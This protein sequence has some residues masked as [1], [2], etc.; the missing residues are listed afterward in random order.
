MC[1]LVTRQAVDVALEKQ[2]SF[3]TS[4]VV[5]VVDEEVFFVGSEEEEE[6]EEEVWLDDEVEV[7][8]LESSPPVSGVGA[9]GSVI[10]QKPLPALYP[11][12]PLIPCEVSIP[13]T[14]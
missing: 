13:V 5:V 12:P 11:T 2:P 6:E 10:Q 8:V 3:L 9:L 4:V 14:H 7:V 1:P